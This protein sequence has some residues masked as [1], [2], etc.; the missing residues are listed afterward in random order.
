MPI[1]TY[2]ITAPTRS[3]MFLNDLTVVD[4]AYIDDR[5]CIVGGSF[6]PCFEVSGT[7]DPIEK[8]VVDFSTIKKD[9]KEAIDGHSFNINNNGF[10]HK[11]WIIEGYS[12][13]TSVRMVGNMVTDNEVTI[14]T[15][16]LSLTLPGDA[17][18]MISQV[19][20]VTPRYT[21][22]YIG[23]AFEAH[24]YEHLEK[25]Y[26][27]INIG[28]RCINS[29]HIHTPSNAVNFNAYRFRYVHGLKDS[30]SYGCKNIAH[31]H[32]SFIS[33]DSDPNGLLELIAK[34]LDD[35]VF[36]RSDNIKQFIRGQGE[37][38]LTIGYDSPRGSFEMVVEAQSHK[39]VVLNTE[40]TV[41]Y[42]AAYVKER[43]GSLM[44]ASDMSSFC[45]SEGLSKG[46]IE[47]L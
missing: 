11:V 33:S 40:T 46:A 2:K 38:T 21:T 43:F 47:T 42:L 24:V 27:N 13:I 23:L 39:I 10:D 31:G 17:V 32:G 12:N 6:N 30:T 18:K 5:G 41:E 35:T 25:M 3:T 20:D 7:P 44:K 22:D 28:V 19:D 1:S 37:S 26:P 4:H 8:V 34:E 14:T 9:I 16:N 45:I 15:P 36:V 29:E